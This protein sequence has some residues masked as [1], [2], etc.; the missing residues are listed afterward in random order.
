MGSSPVPTAQEEADATRA[1]RNRPIA[2]V[3][4]AVVIIICAVIVFVIVQK[5]DEESK[6]DRLIA[7][8]RHGERYPLV[9]INASLPLSLMGQLTPKGLDQMRSLGAD[10]ARKY[11][12]F[13][14]KVRATLIVATEENRCVQS[15]KALSKEINS[16]NV[17]FVVRK[18]RMIELLNY[19]SLEPPL[20]QHVEAFFNETERQLPACIRTVANKIFDM[21]KRLFPEQKFSEH[22]GTFMAFGVADSIDTLRA[23][24][25][26]LPFNLTVSD[27]CIPKTGPIFSD[28]L[29]VTLTNICMESFCRTIFAKFVEELAKSRDGFIDREI[30]VYVGS[31]VHV[32][33]MMMILQPDGPRHRPK[34][35]AN[36]VF[37]I[38]Q[39][40]VHIYYGEDN[41]ATRRS[42][43]KLPLNKLIKLLEAKLDESGK[44]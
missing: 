21:Q 23:A 26:P 10:L 38:D 35:G 25:A 33:A 18:G 12:S 40:D 15:A 20:R 22:Y 13:A 30:A 37:E 1:P 41:S 42:Y 4:I 8:V 7:F 3:I 32:L 43:M 2:L 28:S 31:D 36:L 5:P 6:F 16:V 24:G 14:S 9:P 17:S 19:S 11:R 27:G 44:H 29:F 34:Y 39:K